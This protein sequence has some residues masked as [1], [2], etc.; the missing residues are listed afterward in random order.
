MLAHLGRTVSVGVHQA[1][2]ELHHSV[3]KVGGCAVEVASK[4]EHLL[5]LL[6]KADQL[7]RLE[8]LSESMVHILVVPRVVLGVELLCGVAEVMVF[9]NWN[10]MDN[11]YFRHN[12]KFTSV[13]LISIKC[14]L[15]GG[16]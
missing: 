8:G 7:R 4:D 9:V 1:C 16:F 6:C 3:G 5:R 10:T 11:V 2:V 12:W 14:D 15:L 13:K